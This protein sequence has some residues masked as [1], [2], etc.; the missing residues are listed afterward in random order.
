MVRRKNSSERS[1]ALDCPGSDG[2]RVMEMAK[3]FYRARCECNIKVTSLKEC[4]S[5]LYKLMWLSVSFAE[6]RWLWP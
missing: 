3:C 2:F 4:F 1:E 5:Y 6:Y